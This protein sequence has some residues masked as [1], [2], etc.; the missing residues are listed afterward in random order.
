M[1]STSLAN[2]MKV[3]Y[4]DIPVWREKVRIRLGINDNLLRG[5][6]PECKKQYE[7]AVNLYRT[8]NMTLPEIATVCN[9]SKSG[10]HQHL[11]FYHK[12]ILKQKQE[13]RKNAK[14]Q[15][16]KSRGK[17]LGNGRK[18]EPSP[19]TVEKYAEALDLYKNTDLTLKEIAKKNGVSNG[20][21]RSYLH[22]WHKNLVLE[23]YGIQENVN[24]KIDL[25]KTKCRKKEVAAKYEKAIESLKLNPRPIAKVASEFGFHPETFRDYIHKHEPLLAKQQ[26]M[27]RIKNGRLV[28]LRSEEKYAEAI[29]LYETTT[30]DLKSIAR[31]LGLT[32]NSLGGY[33]RRNYPEVIERHQE[34][35]KNKNKA[36]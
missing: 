31:R 5:V 2:F 29:Q 9:I 15:K 26:G 14:E 36:F 19:K 30:E 6:R 1:D 25:R 18:Y 12:D 24:K 35:L 7:E 10:F 16:S 22:V 21:F 8:T 4:P 27:I 13:Q 11:R 33:V 32:Y 3:H 28:S 17:V 23:R 20:G 34:L